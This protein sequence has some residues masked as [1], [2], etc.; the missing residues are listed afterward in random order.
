[1]H[2]ALIVHEL[3]VEGGGEARRLS[4]SSARAAGPRSHPL[5]LSLRSGQQFFRN[6]TFAGKVAD[7]EMQDFYCACDAFY[8][9]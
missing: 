3:L 8:S 9:E 5:Y 7:E 2:I 4:R 1:M 6:V